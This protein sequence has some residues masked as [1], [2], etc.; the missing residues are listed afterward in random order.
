M[1]HTYIMFY[2]A[3]PAFHHT[4]TVPSALHAGKLSP[5]DDAHRKNLVC[6][7]IIDHIPTYMRTYEVICRLALGLEVGPVTYHSRFVPVVIIL[8]GDTVMR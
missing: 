4:M 1:L 8:L 7:L 6:S 3:V 5:I 2:F